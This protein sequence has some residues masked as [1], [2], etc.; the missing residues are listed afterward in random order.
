MFYTS[1]Y[2]KQLIELLEERKK[3]PKLRPESNKLKTYTKRT[4]VSLCYKVERLVLDPIPSKLQSI[5]TEF[6]KKEYRRII[7]FDIILKMFPNVKEI[8]LRDTILTL[9]LCYK[10]RDFFKTN[11]KNRKLSKIFFNKNS[12]K[13]ENRHV[14]RYEMVLN[15]Y[16]WNVSQ[17]QCMVYRSDDI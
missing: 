16:K 17:S 4:F 3:Y 10:L 12:D 9:R 8:F 11:D 6:K 14:M 7:S 13:M 5:F 1:K 15:P 2:Q